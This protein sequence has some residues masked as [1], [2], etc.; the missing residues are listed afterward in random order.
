MIVKERIQ[1][2]VKNALAEEEERIQIA[3]KNAHERR[4]SRCIQCSL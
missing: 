4:K 3:V 2:A 1:I